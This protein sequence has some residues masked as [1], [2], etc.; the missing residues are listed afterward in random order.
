[1]SF[2]TEPH[3]FHGDISFI[4]KM[5]EKV[6]IPVLQKDFVIDAY[7]IYQAQQVGSDA[8]LLIARFLDKK[9]LQEFVGLCLHLGVEPVVEINNEE[10]FEKAI[11][12]TTNIISVN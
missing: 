5:K 9:T 3:Y 4:P 7:Q 6:L 2:I 10:D 1:I 8:L 12:T 11:A